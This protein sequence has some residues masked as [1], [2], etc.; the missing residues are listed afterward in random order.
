MDVILLIVHVCLALG[1]VTLVMLQKGKGAAEGA[2]FGGGASTVFG[3]RGSSNFLS[4][5]TAILATAFFANSLALAYLASTRE[6]PASV[7]DAIEQAVTESVEV[8]ATDFADETVPL[9]VDAPVD[10]DVPPPATE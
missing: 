1:I 7:V 9:P 3:A 4:K 10:S 8:P 6:M 5:F 2:S